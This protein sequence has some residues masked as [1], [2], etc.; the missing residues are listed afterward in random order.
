L[1]QKRYSL[2]LAR[3]IDQPAV[4]NTKVHLHDPDGGA[5][6][7][8]KEFQRSARMMISLSRPVDLSFSATERCVIRHQIWTR[9]NGPATLDV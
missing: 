5:V 2:G 7:L 8:D 3:K 1:R 9:R 6:Q 4:F